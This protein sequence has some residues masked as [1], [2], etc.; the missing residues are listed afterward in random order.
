MTG[1]DSADDSADKD[2]ITCTI[3]LYDVMQSRSALFSVG[4]GWVTLS[5][6]PEEYPP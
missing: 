4:E 5:M 2:K 3:I 1:S 6:H